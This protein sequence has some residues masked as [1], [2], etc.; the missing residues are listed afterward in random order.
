MTTELWTP[1]GSVLLGAEPAGNNDV[2]GGVVELCTFEFRDPV[3]GRSLPALIGRT[4]DMSRAEVEDLAAQSYETFLIECRHK[5]KKESMT[6]E[7]RKE[8][9]R[10]LKDFKESAR[11]R[12]EANGKRYYAG[13]E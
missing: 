3:T 13:L 12:R 2:T 8:I 11:K 1:S 7:D 4:E 10:V 9:G 5:G 6:P